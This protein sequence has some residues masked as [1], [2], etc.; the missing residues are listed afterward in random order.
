MKGNEAT[1]QTRHERGGSCP[2]AAGPE[3]CPLCRSAH[4]GVRVPTRLFGFLL[5]GATLLGGCV[6]ITTTVETRAS[7]KTEALSQIRLG[8]T[9]GAEVMRLLGPPHSIIRGS[10]RFREVGCLGYY[11]Y[12][13]DRQLS[14][15]DDE[16][17]ALF[18]KCGRAKARSTALLIAG[19]IEGRNVRVQGEELLII[20]NEDTD[21]ITDVASSSNDSSP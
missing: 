17:Y 3:R 15:L 10:A 9:T 19:T 12:A 18:Y 7:L 11:S 13:Q 16:H 1:G 8:E 2:D 4:A 5:T 21:V 6:R 14:S 20:L